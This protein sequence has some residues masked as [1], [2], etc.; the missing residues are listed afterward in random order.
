MGTWR[1]LSGDGPRDAKWQPT[2]IDET[3]I[4]MVTESLIFTTVIYPIMAGK[5]IFVGRLDWG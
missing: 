2:N 5:P 4:A 1:I 3:S